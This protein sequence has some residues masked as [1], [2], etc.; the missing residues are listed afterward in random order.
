MAGSREVKRRIRSIGNTKKITRAM[1]MVSAAKMRRAQIAAAA[2]RPYANLA[3]ELAR[4]VALAT[5][6]MIGGQSVF[7]PKNEA[8][9]AALVVVSPNRGQ[10]GALNSNLLASMRDFVMVQQKLGMN[11]EI[12]AIGNKARDGV[13][14]AGL[15]LEAEFTKS[16]KAVS[17]V[18]IRPAAKLLIE[19]FLNGKYVSV[20]MVFS[21]FVSTL[22]QRPTTKQLLP[23]DED[24]IDGN[25]DENAIAE[26]DFPEKESPYIFEPDQGDVLKM[27]LPR[28]IEAQLYH[29]VLE[30]N[31]SEHSA[32]M[33]MMKN[34]TEAAS[35]LLDDLKLTYNRLRQA[36]ITK[37]LAEITAGR[38]AME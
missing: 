16:D 20:S 6:N 12:I 14:R 33:V 10:V 1:Q 4:A 11:I 7:L 8:K 22:V 24:I 37:E 32:R 26:K 30:T 5:E 3:R 9:T 18:D 38:I 17:T 15:L 21:Q 19:N 29:A 13:L 23:F 35:D 31:A 2:S 36:N 27:L 34:A 25:G 28:I